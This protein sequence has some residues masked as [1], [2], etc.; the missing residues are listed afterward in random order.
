MPKGFPPITLYTLQQ[1]SLRGSVLVARGPENVYYERTVVPTD[2]QIGIG[3][4]GSK[5]NRDEIRSEYLA[6]LANMTASEVGSL[7]HADASFVYDGPAAFQESVERSL[8]SQEDDIRALLQKIARCGLDVPSD[9]HLQIVP[10]VIDQRGNRSDPLPP[11]APRE[12][13]LTR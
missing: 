3:S 13:Q 2:K 11:V 4:C 7:L 5:L 12:I 8:K 6:Q 9:V 1:R 10:E